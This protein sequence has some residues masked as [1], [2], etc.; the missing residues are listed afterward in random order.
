MCGIAGIVTSKDTDLSFI[1]AMTDSMMHR[2]PDGR[3]VKLFNSCLD[4]FDGEDNQTSYENKNYDYGVIALGHRRLSVIDPKTS[5]NQPMSYLESRYWITFNGEIFNYIELREELVGFGYNFLTNSDT[6]VI[7]AAFDKWGVECQNKF[8]GM[9]AFCIIDRKDKKIFLSRDRFGE[10]SLYY[11]VKNN[12]LYFASEIKAIF[13][14]GNIKPFIHREKAETFVKY[15]PNEYTFETIYE[16]IFRLMPGCYFYFN[17]GDDLNTIKQKKYWFLEVNHSKEAFNEKAA[18]K[19]AED[20]YA[21]LKD[22]VKI[23]LRSDVPLGSALSG[24][25]DS[26]SIVYL[27]KEILSEKSTPDSQNTFS[28]VYKDNLDE[29]YCD[30]S[31]FIEL[32]SD[33]LN[34]KNHQ[35]TPKV[36]E[37]PGE[38]E[39]MIYCFDSPPENTCMSGWHTYKLV[40]EKNIVVTLDGQGADEQLTGYLYYFAY[41]LSN[42]RLTDLLRET[43]YS[44]KIPNAFPYV[45]RGFVTNIFSKIFGTSITKKLIENVFN[46]SFPESLNAVLHEDFTTGLVTLL[47][48]ADKGSMAHSVES[49]MP[50]LDF[51][52]VEFLAKVP[53]SYK[54][55]NG[56]SKYLARLA[57]SNKL[58]DEICWRK[59][60]QGWPIPEDSWFSKELNNWLKSSLLELNRNKDLFD[61]YKNT[62]YNSKNKVE[63]LRTLNILQSMKIFNTKIID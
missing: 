63:M 58:P 24:G 21:L 27:V 44:L 13:L 47:H 57:F 18:K 6:E 4:L 45:W 43:Y 25:L 36:Q 3:G 29:Q 1:H 30:E 54:I 5:S 34:I 61:S 60:K 17:L 22:S 12:I 31:F 49:R 15:G 53:S 62:T 32:L 11:S 35:I 33:K 51:R 40:K 41:F 10:K 48:N 20:Y 2:G 55:H 39:R 56:W 52:L 46:R 28:C 14:S 26:S 59:D 16:D 42:L 50:F 19:Y 37:I 7:L 38:Y 8:N 9:W 23:R